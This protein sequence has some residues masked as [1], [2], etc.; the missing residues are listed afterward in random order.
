MVK[1]VNIAHRSVERDI[2]GCDKMCNFL[3]SPLARGLACV[4]E[5][6]VKHHLRILNVTEHKRY[7]RI[8][9]TELL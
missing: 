9:K 8:R 4:S 1:L 7:A 3:E 5:E 6:S 2:W